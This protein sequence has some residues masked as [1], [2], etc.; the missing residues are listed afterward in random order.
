M[1]ELARDLPQ[2][3]IIQSAHQCRNCGSKDLRE[4]GFI[5]ILAGFFLKRVLNAEIITRKS[6][7]SRKRKIQALAAP[8]QRLA[9]RIHP[10]GV[11]VELQS[12]QNCSFIQTKVPFADDAISRLYVDYRSDT[13]N[14]ERCRYEPTYANI[15]S[16]IGQHTESGIGRIEALTA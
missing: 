11:A 4:L 7:H 10:P 13:Y 15:Q 12:C 6:P 1:L 9:A 2:E 3:H 5:G 14:N 16:T 8:L